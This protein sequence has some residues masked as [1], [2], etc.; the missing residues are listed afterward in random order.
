MNRRRAIDDES[1]SA[2]DSSAE[3]RLR[4]DP[5]IP[6]TAN[7]SSD[8]WDVYYDALLGYCDEH[9]TCSMV[10]DTK[11]SLKDGE[12]ID[13]GKWLT[14]QKRSYANGSL[15]HSRLTFLQA[16]VDRNK[17]QWEDIPQIDDSDGQSNDHVREGVT[18][19]SPAFIVAKPTD[20]RKEMADKQWMT[21]FRALVSLYCNQHC[22]QSF[23]SSEAKFLTNAI[24][25][26]F[27]HTCTITETI[28]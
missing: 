20:R 11:Y 15:D 13:L 25:N 14:Q 23:R 16:L 17:F 8:R 21:S 7:D 6:C 4:K 9:G 19:E 10:A 18:K 2:A 22:R 1:S 12:V 28:Y 26:F 5:A 24:F 27:S 3:K